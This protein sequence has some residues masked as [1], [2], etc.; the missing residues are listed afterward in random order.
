VIFKFKENECLH[1]VLKILNRE[2]S[3]YGKMFKETRVSHTT[4]QKVLKYL[5]IK[6]FVLRKGG[7]Y[8]ISEQ[9]KDIF[10]KL[11][12]LKKLL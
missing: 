10:N 2:D 6:G 3:N 5:I 7:I 12:I 4:L 1:G 9:G 11:D 8:G